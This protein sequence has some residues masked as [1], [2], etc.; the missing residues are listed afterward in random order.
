MLW[1]GGVARNRPREWRILEPPLWGRRGSL[2][3]PGLPQYGIWTWATFLGS[4]WIW[5]R[6]WWVSE[7][8]TG[9]V[10]VI[11]MCEWGNEGN[12]DVW[13]EVGVYCA[14]ILSDKKLSFL[15]DE[16]EKL[17]FFFIFFFSWI[18]L[19]FLLGHRL[20]YFQV[21]TFPK[22]WRAINFDTVSVRYFILL[23]N[24]ILL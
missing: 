1:R 9:D 4:P 6:V 15:E 2:R 14:E 13:G 18:I 19:S 21:L 11:G 3:K 17:L 12:G 7:V 16:R 22:L 10:E 5:E 20:C 24:Y 23:I 8:V